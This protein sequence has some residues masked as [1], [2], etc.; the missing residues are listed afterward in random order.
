VDPRHESPQFR[1][2]TNENPKG[3]T[4]VGNDLEPFNIQEIHDEARFVDRNPAY[5]LEKHKAK[6]DKRKA[7]KK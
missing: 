1:W 4:Y 5:L 2:K 6:V 3:H 7:K